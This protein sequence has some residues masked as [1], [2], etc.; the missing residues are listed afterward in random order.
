MI[1]DDA[2]QLID[3]ER[4]RTR[5]FVPGRH[6]ADK[7]AADL[8]APFVERRAQQ[9]DDGWP[10]GGSARLANEPAE[11]FGKLAAI[12]HRAREGNPDYAHS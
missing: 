6:L 1:V 8:G 11:F 3:Q 7:P 2:H 12:D 5:H 9:F 4:L 10:R